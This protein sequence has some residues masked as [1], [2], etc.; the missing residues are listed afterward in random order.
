M[1]CTTPVMQLRERAQQFTSGCAFDIFQ[2]SCSD[3]YQI[4]FL[5]SFPNNFIFSR[6]VSPG[7]CSYIIFPAFVF[8]LLQGFF[9]RLFPQIY[10]APPSLSPIIFTLQFLFKHVQCNI[11]LNMFVFVPNCFRIFLPNL[12]PSPL[13]LIFVFFPDFF[14]RSRR[15]GGGKGAHQKFF[16]SHYSP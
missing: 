2:T 15:E 14:S 4:L 11:F 13:S 5:P 16:P 6:F 7:I 9:S 8:Y 12:F 10:F 1:L 3:L